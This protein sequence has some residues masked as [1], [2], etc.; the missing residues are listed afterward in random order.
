MVVQLRQS[1]TLFFFNCPQVDSSEFPV[2]GVAHAH[3]FHAIARHSMAKIV[4]T[5]NY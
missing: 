3:S 1:K 5:I 4:D 2:P